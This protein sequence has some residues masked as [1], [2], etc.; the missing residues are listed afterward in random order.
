MTNYNERLDELMPC[1][2]KFLKGFAW[3]KGDPC[4]GCINGR[5]KQ[6]ITSLIKELVAEAKPERQ[7]PMKMG[8]PTKESSDLDKMIFA[9]KRGHNEAI[10]EFEQNLLKALEE[11]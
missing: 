9:K 4:E 1:D 2:C 10:D 5:L 3:R 6:A 7:P 11:V 8:N